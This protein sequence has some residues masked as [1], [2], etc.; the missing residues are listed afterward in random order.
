M[1]ISPTAPTPEIVR[2]M[3]AGQGGRIDPTGTLLGGQYTVRVPY[4]SANTNTGN[5]AWINPESGTVIAKAFFVIAGSAGTGTFQ[6]GRGTDGTGTSAT[7]GM[8]NLGTLDVVGV[9][10]QVTSG[11]AAVTS[12]TAGFTNQG[13]WLI[14]P[15]GTGTNNSIIARVID[16]VVGTM[17]NTFMLVTYFKAQ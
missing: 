8:I 14:G 9:I 17:D 3:L 4:A 11:S 16:G 2:Y 15:G 6:M 1:P 12:G 7:T 5:P 13:W 10:H